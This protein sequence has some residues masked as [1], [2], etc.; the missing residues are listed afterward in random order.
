MEKEI[1]E[2]IRAKLPSELSGA[3]QQYYAQSEIDK[4]TIAALRAELEQIKGY[5]KTEQADI[6]RLNK[7][8]KVYE[9]K[10]KE[11]FECIHKFSEWETKL[12]ERENKLEIV[13]YEVEYER[14]MAERYREMFSLIFRN[15]EIKEKIL[16]KT[17]VV[18]QKYHSRWDS[19]CGANVT[20][21]FEDYVEEVDRTITKE[22]E[23]K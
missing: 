12:I 21:A 15:T 18:R 23:K 6:E 22:T 4:K 17:P 9:L 13:K 10:R 14:I 8:I 20:E 1:I 5:R 19:T 11:M 7:I 3:F 16:E 2:I